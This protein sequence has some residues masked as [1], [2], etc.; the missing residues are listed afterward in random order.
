[1]NDASPHLQNLF[2]KRRNI[3]LRVLTR[4]LGA[5]DQAE[6]VLQEALILFERAHRTESINNPDAYLM[7]IALNLAVDRIRQDVSRRKRED[8]WFDAHAPGRSGDEYVAATPAPDRVVIAREEIAQMAN[9]LEELSPKVRTAFILHKIRGL[10]HSE[11]AAEM[12]LSKST[13]EKHIMKAMKSIMARRDDAQ[14]AE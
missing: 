6:D 4:R 10:S 14:S 5:M 2:R 11:T 12:G 13:V 3:F 7:Q 1:M 8:N 9:C